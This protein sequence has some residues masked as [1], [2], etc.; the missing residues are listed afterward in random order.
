MTGTPE[1]TIHHHGVERHPLIVIDDFWP[2][3]EALREDAASL[4]MGSIGP[5]YP[6][7]RATVPPRLADT[8]RR[9]IAPLLAE[10]F[11]LDPAPA[12]SE[13]Y[14]SLVTTAPADLAPIQRLPHFDGVERRRIAVLL[15]LGHGDQ[16]GTAF[17]RQRATGYESVDGTRLDRFRATLDADVRTHG[18]PDAAYI[19]GDTPMY[20]RIAVQPAVFNRALV[21][22]GNTL[23]CAYLPPEVVLSADPLAGRLTL[24]LFLF[25]D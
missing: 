19:A 11:G 23:H 21:Y 12:I 6:G 14:Y 25:D 20:E 9:R 5:H 4:R 10:H 17:Y 22:A 7:V 2:D 13:A 24:N 16:G 15:F 3:P 1:I 18:L 8:M